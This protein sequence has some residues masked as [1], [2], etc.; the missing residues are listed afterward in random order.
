M[1]IKPQPNWRGDPTFL[2]DVFRAFGVNFREY[3]GWKQWGMGDFNAIQG[4]MWH[5]TGAANTS[6]EYIRNN[7]RL[8]NGL[9]SQLHT[10]PDGLQTI[11]GAGIAWH[12]GR[13]WLDGWP[14]NNANAVSIGFEMQHNG[15]SPWPEK[16]LESTRRATAAILWFLGKRAT[17]HTMIAHWEYSNAAQGKWDPG[18]GNGRAGAMMNMNHQRDLVN[19]LIDRFNRYGT[20]DPKPAPPVPKPAPKPASHPL[21]QQYFTDFFG[22]YMGNVVSDMKDVRQQLTGGRDRG[23]YRGWSIEWLLEQYN[24]RQGDY[25][26]VPELL[27]VAITETRLARME[28]AEIKQTLTKGAK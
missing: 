7:P 1:T 20:L 22:G 12:A 6:P 10:A 16:Q 14:T 8:G 17:K 24:K 21:T 11:L 5:H 4:V 27:S 19:K 18:A 9:S 25:G 28:L 26:T 23:D 3:K 13:G 2:P 15:V